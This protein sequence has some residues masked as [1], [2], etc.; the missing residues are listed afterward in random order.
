MSANFDCTNGA[1]LVGDINRSQAEW[2]IQ[3]TVPGS[4]ELTTAAIARVY[5]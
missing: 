3:A 5:V 1:S 4:S 2:T